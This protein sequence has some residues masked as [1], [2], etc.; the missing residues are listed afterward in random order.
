MNRKIVNKKVSRRTV[1]K[2]MTA[3]ASV[4]VAPAFIKNLRAADTIKVGIISPL[5]GAWTV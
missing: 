3:A 5:T 1:L 2:G 4:A